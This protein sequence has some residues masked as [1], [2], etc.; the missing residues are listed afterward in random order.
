MVVGVVG[1]WIAFFGGRYYLNVERNIWR[2]LL[3]VCAIPLVLVFA[4]IIAHLA[5]D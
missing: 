5:F 2:F 1:F 3:C 4:T